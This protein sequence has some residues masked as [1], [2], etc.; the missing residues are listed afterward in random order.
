[1]FGRRKHANELTTPPIAENEQAVEVLRVWA[2]PGD[3][4][5][6]TLRV[7]WKQP[8]AWGLMFVGRRRATRSASV[9]PR[10]PEPR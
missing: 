3:P 8:A 10:R 2:G 7:T 9:R 1:M 6:M 4:Q 5:Q